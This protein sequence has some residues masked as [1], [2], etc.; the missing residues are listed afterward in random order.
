MVIH[1]QPLYIQIVREL[2]DRIENEEYEN[3]S[4]LPSEPELAEE[5]G[6]SRGT[7]REALSIL[8]KDGYLVREHGKGSYVRKKKKVVAGIE[9]MTSLTETIR[10]AGYDSK[11]HV[12]GIRFETLSKHECR[13]LDLNENCTGY[14]VESVKKADNQAVIYCYDVIPSWLVASDELMEERKTVESTSKFFTDKLN[15]QPDQF[16]S[17]VR[18]V[19]AE[20]PIDSILGVDTST[21]LILM[22]GIMTDKEGKVLNYGQQYFNSDAYQFRLVRK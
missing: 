15:V 20:E 2:E 12:L 7:L 18:A 22:D 6:V 17:K 5:F 10:N 4:R 19:I 1:K 9:K 16:I 11:D 13:M 14:I 3:G 8:E 21:P